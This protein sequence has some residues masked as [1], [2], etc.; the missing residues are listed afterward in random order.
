MNT[1]QEVKNV[2]KDKY[3]SIAVK[4]SGCGC[5][6]GCGSQQVEVNMIGDEYKNV[7]GHIEEADLGLGCGI[8]TVF[9]DIKLNDIVLDLGSGAG[10]DVFIASKLVGPLGKV[11]GVDM[12]NEMIEKA[13]YN[14]AKLNFSNVEFRLGEIEYLP[15]EDNSIDV[16]LSNCV[17]NLVPDKNK[18]FSE[19]YRTLKTNGHFCI[20]DI[21]TKGNLPEKLK[22]SAEM[23]AGCVSGAIQQSDY[24]Q[25]I[26]QT[27]FENVEIK[28][29]KVIELPDNLLSEYLN[30]AE[31]KAFRE[32]EIGVFSITVQAKK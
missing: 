4:E 30:E 16:V 25:I 15:I 32:N 28:K 26:Q 13:N 20:S 24:L 23:Y 9:A 8:P 7:D 6:C 10:N 11:I 18:A 17:L 5:S 3:A 19:I 31:I 21:V 14:K 12:T 2:V 1:N 27:G 22:K 29:S